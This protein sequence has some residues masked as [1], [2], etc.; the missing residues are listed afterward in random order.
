M[1]NDK[2]TPSDGAQYQFD[3]SMVAYN[4][5]PSD[6]RHIYPPAST[7]YLYTDPSSYSN[8]NYNNIAKTKNNI[9]FVK[10]GGR[11]LITYK[12][13][14]LIFPIDQQ[15]IVLFHKLRHQL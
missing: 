15:I 2:P 11:A 6:G 8:N 9:T 3:I 5:D 4:N 1:A 7:S 13:Y 14:D 12:V 10:S